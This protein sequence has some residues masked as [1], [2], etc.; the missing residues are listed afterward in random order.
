MSNN[1]TLLRECQ[2]RLNYEFRDVALLQA[3]LRHAS[4]ASSR[5]ESNER[6]EF[7]GDAVLDLVIC[8]D[9]YERLPNA[10][11]G[12]LT[13]IKSAV[14][15]R[16]VCACVADKL[17]LPEALTLGQGMEPDDHLPRSLAAAVLESIIAA[18]YL[19]GGLEPVRAFILEHAEDEIRKAVHSDH[20]YNFKSQLQQHAQRRLHATPTYEL[21]D[22]KGPDHS[23]CFEIA[24][25]VGRQQFPGA[26]G[27]NKK[28]A[29]QKAAWLALRELGAVT[30]EFPEF[31]VDV[32]SSTL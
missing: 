14:V 5:R 17:R 2:E 9:L 24:V 22:E 21:L 18:I 23:K 27:P 12:E 26:W 32:E 4:S 28:D 20:Q 29:E 16:R 11:E 10:L 8:Q 30:G 1:S 25:T 15:S 6:L 3:A 13:K 7:L 19:D 31:D